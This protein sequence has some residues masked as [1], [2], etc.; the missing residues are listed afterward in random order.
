MRRN[1]FSMLLMIFLMNA[2]PPL[3]YALDP[4][5]LGPASSTNIKKN[6]T[7]ITVAK[8]GG[9]YKTIS[10]ALNAVTDASAANTYV[11]KVMPGTYEESIQMKPYVDVVGSGQENT[12]ITSSSA[13]FTVMGAD[14]STIENIWVDSTGAK[15]SAQYD[16]SAII[17]DETSMTMNNIKV[18]MNNPV[19]PLRQAFGIQTIGAASKPIISNCTV[20]AKGTNQWGLIGIGGEGGSPKITDCNIT[21]DTSGATYSFWNV[22]IR[23]KGGSSTVKNST[24]KV[25][26]ADYNQGIQEVEH[27]Q[28][29]KIKVIATS[30][31]I[32]NI[33][34]EFAKVTDSEIVLEGTAKEIN[35]AI[36][37]ESRV[38]RSVIEGPICDKKS[39]IL[40]SK[41]KKNKPIPNQ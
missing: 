15:E 34:I 33:G 40:K 30:T 11:I 23:T 16:P 13:D 38:E 18:T 19:Q 20:Y 2:L 3:T 35:C 37:R 21:I 27:I 1:T 39:K 12:K 7:V 32:S 24:I 10:E 6:A 4:K 26:G 25:T 8:T 41:N 9:D 22:G 31:S 5:S 17:N 28:R 29:S 14:N 36:L